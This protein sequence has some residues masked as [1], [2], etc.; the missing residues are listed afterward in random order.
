MTPFI[1]CL[2]HLDSLS[3]FDYDGVKLIIYVS[4]AI[5]RERCIGPE[6]FKHPRF[7]ERERERGRER[8]SER[9]RPRERERKRETERESEREAT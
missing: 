7:R 2:F 8:E 1:L 4:R 3:L 5:Q 9:R 6:A